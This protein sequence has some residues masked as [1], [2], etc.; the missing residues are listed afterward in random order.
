MCVG[1]EGVHRDSLYLT[2]NF[3]VNLKLPYKIQY[4]KN[5]ISLFVVLYEVYI[6]TINFLEFLLLSKSLPTNGGLHDWLE[7]HGRVKLRP[8]SL[9]RKA[10][11]RVNRRFLVMSLVVDLGGWLQLV[12]EDSSAG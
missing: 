8:A 12:K 6:Y 4:I 2:F 3:V 7:S 5:K 10:C 1:R 9:E 11:C